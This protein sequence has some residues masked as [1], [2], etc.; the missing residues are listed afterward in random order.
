MYATART[1]YRESFPAMGNTNARGPE[2]NCGP[3]TTTGSTKNYTDFVS[4]LLAPIQQ[5]DAVLR[6]PRERTEQRVDG[7]A[8]VRRRK[9]V[10]ERASHLA[11]STLAQ[12]TT[13]TFIVRHEP[14]AATARAGRE[15][16]RADHGAV[17]DTLAIVGHTHTYGKTARSKSRS[18]TAERRSLGGVGTAGVSSSSVKMARSR[19]T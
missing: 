3:G 16:E 18:A 15:A 6:A 8:R 13:Y 10:D 19:S 2:F 4:T 9:R 17:S 14:K 12:P 11:A 5:S 7:E 1:K